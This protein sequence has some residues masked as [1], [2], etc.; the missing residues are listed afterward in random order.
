MIEQAHKNDIVMPLFHGYPPAPSNGGPLEHA[1]AKVGAWVWQPKIDDWRGVCHAPTSRVWSQYGDK[2][3][4][5]SQGK[6]S[7]ALTD[8]ELI[9]TAERRQGFEWFD[10]GIM[11]N[12][13]DMMRGAIIVF[14][15]MDT[16]HLTQTER[17]AVLEGLFP[18]L[19]MASEL[20]KNGHTRGGVYLV[21]E[22]RDDS[23]RLFPVILQADLQ[24]E[25]AQLGRKFYEGL[26]AKRADATYPLAHR[27]KAKTTAWV[28]HRFDQ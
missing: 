26:V 18:V 16:Q 13:H 27:P 12:R 5:A 17:R 22:W 10:I 9:A 14:D 7:E 6:L 21:N 28:K 8:L 11:E 24:R 19:P 25:N 2:S 4:I 20:L 15:A 1:P 3:T 23:S